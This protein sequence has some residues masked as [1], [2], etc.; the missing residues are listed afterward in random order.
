[1]C[2]YILLSVCFLP[3][4]V[5]SAL[6]DITVWEGGAV[7]CTISDLNHTIRINQPGTYGFRAE[8]D[9]QLA[10]IQ[11]IKVQ[12]GVSGTVTVKIAYDGT[13]GDGATD[14]WEINLD[15]ATTGIL[16]ELDIEG[17]LGEVAGVL[18]DSVSGDVLVGGDLHETF[19][20]GTITGDIVIAG[21]LSG[22]IEG[23][24]IAS[25]DVNGAGPHTGNIDAASGDLGAVDITGEMA[26]DITCAT[27]SGDIDITGKLSGNLVVDG[28][29]SN[30][31]DIGGDLE[32]NMELGEGSSGQLTGS[33]IIDGDVL[34]T[35][36]NH[37]WIYQMDGGHFEC[38]DMDLGQETNDP[39]E[40]EWLSL[41]G[42]LAALT[43]EQTGTLDIR[44]TLSGVLRL[45]TATADLAIVI[46][47][48][49]A[50]RALLV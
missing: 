31:I 44:D 28:D 20:G 25:V 9:S 16:A 23:D 5:S 13:G 6:A 37:V 8:R 40:Y 27:L 10:E 29:M 3:C 49:D 45:R 42:P 12:S 11:W 18:V 26:G 4:L 2:R 50:W 38:G 1:M 34:D 22:D 15:N 21:T 39:N 43:L 41:G 48:D 14:V 35:G 7:N 24:S 32:G 46:G 17:D 19:D 30:A 47:S 33:V 36:D